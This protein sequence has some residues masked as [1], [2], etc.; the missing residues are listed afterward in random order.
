[1][2]PTLADLR[3]AE[4]QALVKMWP[5]LIHS[6]NAQ[7]M[8]KVRPVNVHEAINAHAKLPYGG[9]SSRQYA[10]RWNNTV[11]IIRGRIK[12]NE[13]WRGWRHWCA[14]PFYTEYVTIMGRISRRLRKAENR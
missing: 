8:T 9:G 7:K 14:G 12:R 13:P 3:F 1:M 5:G 10:T 2:N 4:Y 6:I 11:H